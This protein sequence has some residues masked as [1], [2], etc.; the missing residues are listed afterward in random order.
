MD[1]FESLNHP[2]RD[3]PL[4]AP[5]SIV[6]P[7]QNLILFLLERKCLSNMEMNIGC[8]QTISSRLARKPRKHVALITIFRNK[9]FTTVR[10]EVI[11]MT[12]RSMRM[13]ERC[14]NYHMLLQQLRPQPL[15]VKLMVYPTNSR[16]REV[17]LRDLIH[18]R[19]HHWIPILKNHQ[20]EK[21]TKKYQHLQAIPLVLQAPDSS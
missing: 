20:T 5:K 18:L 6:D 11:T 15:K 2:V 1:P 9:M 13:I 12:R 7:T 16:E 14:Q 3:S 19:R 17:E 10:R 4:A 8:I 21:D